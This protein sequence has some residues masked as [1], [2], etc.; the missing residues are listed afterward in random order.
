MDLHAGSCFDW[1]AAA[2]GECLGWQDSNA[3]ADK[4]QQMHGLLHLMQ[5]SLR[6]QTLFLR[7]AGAVIIHGPTKRR[8]AGNRQQS[9]G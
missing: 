1:H 8:G 7:I 9:G 2:A 6:S 3:A 5:T 4:P